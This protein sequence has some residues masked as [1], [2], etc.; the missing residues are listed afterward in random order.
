[1]VRFVEHHVAHAA[2]P[3]FGWGSDGEPILVLTCDGDGD[4]L[5][6]SVSVGREGRLQRL[7]AIPERESIGR[8]YRLVTFL[9]GMVPGEHEHKVM[10]LAPYA[11][12]RGR[13]EVLAR[14]RPLLRILE[15]DGRRWVRSKGVP[16]T[17]CNKEYFRPLL[18]G[19]R[20]DWICA[21]L[22]AWTEE[23]LVRWVRNCIAATG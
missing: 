21:G 22:Q 11:P 12:D 14:L 1:R 4:G 10:G 2:A 23:L 20:F 18:E 16:E 7:T 17:F 13:D 19:M 9:L 8:V 6:A 5:C 15:G 3:Y